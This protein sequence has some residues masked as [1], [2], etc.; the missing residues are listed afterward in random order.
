MNTANLRALLQD[1]SAGSFNCYRNIKAST[2]DD[3]VHLICDTPWFQTQVETAGK[4][5]QQ[6]KCS[7]FIGNVTYISRLLALNADVNADVYLFMFVRSCGALTIYD[8]L[9]VVAL[10]I[11]NGADTVNKENIHIIQWACECGNLAVVALL[12][13][14]DIRGTAVPRLYNA[15]RKT[16]KLLEAIL[17]DPNE[18]VEITKARYRAAIGNDVYQGN[19]ART[20]VL[21]CMVLRDLPLDES[22][23]ALVTAAERDCIMQVHHMVYP[24][25]GLK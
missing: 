8:Q 7:L 9:G 24:D 16:L 2:P 21:T 23:W 22:D 20:T 11:A 3:I 6:F 18:A 15:S 4:L 12:I 13:A 5:Q 19:T 10:L 1:P 25:M 14:K 17:S